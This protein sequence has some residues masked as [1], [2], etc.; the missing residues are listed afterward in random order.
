ML[1][2]SRS[3]LA[4]LAAT[5][6][7]FAAGPASAQD[8]RGEDGLFVT[9]PNPVT[10]EG[11][12][13]VKAQV[14]RSRNRPDRP[15][16]TIVFDFNPDGKD[17]AT[18]D[19]GTCFDLA[20]YIRGLHD[21]TTV[22]FVHK[23]VSGHAVLPVLA[24]KELV[25]AKGA[26]IGEVIAPNAGGLTKFQAEGY[27]N[28]LG[29][30]REPL[31][32]VVRKMFDKDVE[33]MKGLKNQADWY[34]D[35]RE[36]DKEVAAGV[37]GVNPE[38]VF[39]GGQ[40]ALYTAEQAQRVGLC[41]LIALTRRE[42]AEAYQL[43]PAAL[44][45]DPLQGRTPSA[46]WIVL[47]G[48]VN[49]AMRETLNR[50]IRWVA[51]Q[52][53]NLL[54]LQLE[55]G[56]G[57]A[58]AARGIADDLFRFQQGDDNTAP[59]LLVAFI[60]DKANDMATFLALAC[61]EIVMSKRTDAKAGDEKPTPATLGDFGGLFAPVKPRKGEA[62]LNIDFVKENLREVAERRGYPAV[63]ADGM[64]DRN[65]VI[66]QVRSAKNANV[67]RL[68]SDAELKQNAKDW[69]PERQIKAAGQ[70]LKLDAPLA[71]ELGVARYTVDGR[72]IKE[73]F[74]LYGVE[75]GK[76]RQATPDWLDKLAEF[77]RRPE[78]SV[79]LIMVGIGCLII[80]M[81]VPGVTLP[82]VI[83]A[84]CFLL[85]FWAQS[86]MSGQLVYLAILLF[87][88]GLVL[89][90]LEIFVLPGFGVA[91][92]S[93][94]VFVLAGLALA[95][96]DKMPQSTGEWFDLSGTVLQFGVGFV[97][98]SIGALFLARYLPSIPYAN[99][100]MLVPPTEKAGAD[101]ADLSSVPGAAAAAALFG[102]IG[103]AATTLRPAGMARFGEQFVDVITEGGFVDAGTRIQVVEV[104]GN[105]IVVKPV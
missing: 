11:V 79:L 82:G 54:F 46:F 96:V 88:L 62:P 52:R 17:S 68:M 67:R 71:Y 36:Q 103:V 14:D 56:G 91:G 34:F 63:L 61:S 75:P 87:L 99:R 95:T 8:L 40:V 74:T 51:G 76:V 37:V 64:L 49:G 45:G 44:N 53:G 65:L 80:E 24:C 86:Q 98:A 20:E 25:M 1:A 66:Q 89:I 33:V 102:A 93:G 2:P 57:D 55:C 60:P 30:P 31:H 85:F 21:V 15:V 70:L 78:V 101:A 77:L 41:K 84:L 100:L 94:I 50:R 32:A 29:T 7:M 83:A 59:L 69:V 18:P 28:I 6:L 19:F 23:K 22:A 92:V 3:R 42:V 97:V 72:D 10:S 4:A 35:R 5:L 90:G 16:R 38:P 73:V 12:T 13:R 39:P 43:S 27:R 104:E 58:Q 81:K 48:E 26:L 9:V 47:N 105:R